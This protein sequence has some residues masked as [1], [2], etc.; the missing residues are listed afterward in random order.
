MRNDRT[1]RAEWTSA[2]AG[3]LTPAD[4][5]HKQFR[6]ARMGGGYRMREVDEFLDQV[7]D[8][9][10][11]L[12]A[13]NERLRR[14]GASQPTA[15]SPTGPITAGDRAAIEAFLRREKAFLQSLGGLVQGHAEELKEMVRSARTP[16]D[17]A[18][19]AAVVPAAAAATPVDAPPVEPAVAVPPVEDVVAATEDAPDQVAMPPAQDDHDDD[20]VVDASDVEDE[21]GAIP[22][23]E[24]EAD[25]GVG[26]E[27]PIRLDEPE[28]ARSSRTEEGSAGSLRELFW[29]EE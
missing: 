17:I 5:Q 1:D 15:A 3:Q 16:A 23:A 6:T 21:S 19:P 12:I 29:G 14:G 18:T 24:A 26:T 20:R 9:L 8:T 2:P 7:T 27:E 11:S 28:P 10:T 22:E 25:A 4:V 13:E